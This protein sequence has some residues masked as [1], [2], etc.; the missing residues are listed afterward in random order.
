MTDAFKQGYMDK[1]AELRK[2]S[3]QSADHDVA[4]S[5][6]PMFTPLAAIYGPANAIGMMIGAG[7]GRDLSEEEIEERLKDKKPAESWIPG[8]GGYRM[9]LRT[10]VSNS[11]VRD[12]AKELGVKRVRPEWNTVM[13]SMS[14]GDVLTGGLGRVGGWIGSAITDHRDLE[15]QIEHDKKVRFWKNFL[16]PGYGAYNQGKRFGVSREL[17]DKKKNKSEKDDESDKED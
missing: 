14:L 6:L 13:E 17:L 12:K 11:A 16:I 8:V 2:Q 4:A 7:S 1:M 3:E 10:G 9:G 15:D 5:A